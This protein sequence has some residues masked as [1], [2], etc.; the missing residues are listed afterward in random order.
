MV[1]T[2]KI[3]GQSESGK[4]KGQDGKDKSGKENNWQGNQRQD[5]NIPIEREETF[6]SSSQGKRE[7]KNCYAYFR[8]D[9]RVFSKYV[10][11][12]TVL[13]PRKFFPLRF[14]KGP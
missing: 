11:E 4:S 5:S 13:F 1:P 2:E 3:H 9:V 8:R 10:G 14:D 12:K 6:P 7:F